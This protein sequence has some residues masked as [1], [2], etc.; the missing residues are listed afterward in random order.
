MGVAESVDGRV[1]VL[2]DAGVGVGVLDH[3]ESLAPLEGVPL[4]SGLLQFGPLGLHRVDVDT[5]E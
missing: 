4:E 5:G 3:L 2:D 1:R